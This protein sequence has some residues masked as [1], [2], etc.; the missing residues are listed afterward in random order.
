MPECAQ[1][2]RCRIALTT[3]GVFYGV[4]TRKINL[5]LLLSAHRD[6]IIAISCLITGTTVIGADHDDDLEHSG[7]VDASFFAFVAGASSFIIPLT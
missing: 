3:G 7:L 5:N 6:K 1:R 4:R 2:R